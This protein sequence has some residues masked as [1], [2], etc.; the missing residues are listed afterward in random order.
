MKKLW[1]VVL[2]VMTFI[3]VLVSA[4]AV[5][6]HELDLKYDA[7]KQWDWL[8]INFND[9]K[10]YGRTDRA[11]NKQ[12]GLERS[13]EDPVTVILRRTEALLADV[14][15]MGPTKDLAPLEAK[16]EALK[17]EIAAAPKAE[18]DKGKLLMPGNKDVEEKNG[19]IVKNKDVRFPL[20]EKVYM[21]QREIAFANPLLDFDKILFIKRNPPAY[22]HM[23]D[24]YLGI[25]QHPGGGLY[26]LD[27]AFTDTVQVRDVLADSTVE[28]G[29]LQGKK[30]EPGSFLSPDLSFD[31]EKI[32]FAFTELKEIWTMESTRTKGKLRW[33]YKDTDWSVENTFHIFSV[34]ADGSNLQM[35]TDGPF[36]DFDPCFIPDGRIAFISERRGGQGRCHPRRNATNYVLHSMLPD[37]SDIV[38][39]S[40]H[41][42][43]E[44]SPSINNQGEIVYSRWDY[45]DRDVTAGE[46]P[47][48]T[49][50]DG[51]DAR[52]IHGNY[53]KARMGQTEFDAMAIPNTDSLYLAT[54]SQ[55]HNSSYGS[56]ARFD[57]SVWDYQDEKNALMYFTPDSGSG[58]G[59]GT[60]A[61]PWP[62]GENYTLAVF[63]PLAPGYWNGLDKDGPPFETPVKHGIYVLD[64]F[65]NKILV[66]RDKEI[67]L[68]SP[69]PFRSRPT[70][71]RMPHMTKYAYPPDMQNME[72]QPDK[73]STVAVMNVYNSLFPMPE[74]RKIK[75]LR[76]VQLY[77]KPTIGQDNPNIGYATMMNAR[78]SMGTV[79]VEE[80][81]SV[82]FL[83]P[84]K[85]PVY[86]QAL[87]K[88]GLA[89]QS[90]KSAV[91][92]HPGEMLSC[93][94]CHEPKVDP[95]NAQPKMPMAMKR[96]P[97]ELKPDVNG[98]EPVNFA[99]LVQ[100]VL[101]AKCV[102]CHAKNEKAPDLS[103]KTK[104]GWS[105]AYKNLEP[106]AWYVSGRRASKTKD[107]HQWEAGSRSIPGEN[108]A[109]V[110]KLY[111][112]LT[113]GSHKD[114]VQL[115]DEE[116]DRLTLWMDLNSPFLGAYDDQRQQANGE[117]VVPKLY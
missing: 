42:T 69:I 11:Y 113:T 40:Y 41:E 22:A 43:N 115:T 14:K 45:V 72:A 30:L 33:S 75:A 86:F 55:H 108:G 63:S 52:A 6:T 59:D 71:P 5:E 7:Q 53:D 114:K 88:D 97:S 23:V 49:K 76:V 9:R 34:N 39:L 78:T 56:I 66:Y 27:G 79:P 84:P 46:Y 62:L 31:G 8:V 50:P 38:P 10:M 57:S 3:P 13:D 15:K 82:H 95:V 92:T 98:E 61:T 100:P 77:P 91:Y 54:L 25:T 65:G 93:Q 96:A 101:D 111:K 44:W 106:Y 20:F 102:E 51:R 32:L 47:W 12:A 26:V 112:M 48:V 64:A 104:R 16:L 37:G 103:G 67:S 85:I 21:L 58:H 90:M 74:G 94:G 105:E 17:K 81:G 109:Y 110:S 70:P 99:R 2:I 19:K 116:M 18:W 83:M 80:D 60:Y 35:L 24:Q 29:R 36:N 89:V 87:D 68:H 107:A 4:Q 73:M 117:L 1:I 28:N